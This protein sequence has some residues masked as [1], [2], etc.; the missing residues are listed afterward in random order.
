ME[1]Y[2]FS[3]LHIDSSFDIDVSTVNRF[4][5][6][7]LSTAGVSYPRL[8]NTGAIFEINKIL[9]DQKS[10]L[11]VL[12]KAD[13]SYKYSSEITKTIAQL[14]S[15]Q[16]E[17]ES[18]IN[19]RH[20]NT[21]MQNKINDLGLILR[22]YEISKVGYLDANDVITSAV[23][24]ISDTQYA[25]DYFMFV[26][27][28]DFT[29]QA[30]SLINRLISI[31]AGV[32]VTLYEN[33]DGHNAHIYPNQVRDRLTGICLKKGYAIDNVQSQWSQ[34]DLHAFLQDYLFS[35]NALGYCLDDHSISLYSTD[36]FDDEIEF[37]ARHIRYAVLNGARY[38]DFGICVYGLEQ[39]ENVIRRV[40][41]KYEINHYI[42]TKH[43]IRHT[44]L[45]RFV[46]AFLD[47]QIA[48]SDDNIIALVNSVY[49]P[50]D[51]LQK[52]TIIKD[53]EYSG[54]NKCSLA[55]YLDY[56]DRLK[57]YAID[58]SAS[59][60]Q[61]RDTICRMIADFSV[62]DINTA[63][64]GALDDLYDQKVIENSLDSMLALMDEIVLHY[65]ECDLGE[66]A[67]IFTNALA[68][69][70]ISPLP[71]SMDTV[72]VVEASEN[73]TKFHKL[74]IMNCTNATCP[75]V[76]QDCGVILDKDISALDRCAEISPSIMHINKLNKFH[77]LNS[78]QMFDTTLCITMS[79]SS[80]VEK[81]EL[82]TEL[83]K[84]IS[85]HTADGGEIGL[86]RLSP[87]LMDTNIYE[88]LSRVDLA[89]NIYAKNYDSTTF[90]DAVHILPMRDIDDITPD[91]VSIMFSKGHISSSQIENYFK[92]PFVHFVKNGLKIKENDQKNIK[93]SEIGTIIHSMVE[94]YYTRQIAPDDIETFVDTFV[95]S[96]YHKPNTRANRQICISVKKECVRLL[97]GLA[98]ND[99]MSRFVPTYFELNF[100][101]NKSDFSA[102]PLGDY[103]LKGKVDRVDICD[104]YFRIVDFKTGDEKPDYKDI[105]FGTKIQ[106]FLYGMAL[107][108]CLGKSCAGVFY[109]PISQKYLKDEKNTYK[110]N[111][112]FITENDMA[113]RL[114]VT[115]E[116]EVK[117]TSDIV[118][119]KIKKDGSLY[120]NNY[121]LTSV[122]L[123][124]IFAYVETLATTAIR[125][126]Q[127]GN[128]YPSPIAVQGD[129]CE[130]CDF[131]PL[132]RKNSFSIQHRK[133]G[134][135]KKEDI[136][137]EGDE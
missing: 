82:V 61:V 124:Q 81:S 126:I 114:D 16:I 71:Q 76:I 36:S 97:R 42:D 43:S 74:F 70:Y 116:P 63:I 135:I 137:G 98:Q 111:G 7:V 66:F 14:K 50:F 115:L 68:E 48:P 40:L 107:Q 25:D 5:Q 91:N 11:K 129:V 120:K 21:Q 33:K 94:Q 28:D 29:F 101:R 1:K 103:D 128:I 65:P 39:Y 8:T 119:V 37:V 130:Y 30:Y 62:S 122:E 52:S 20:K 125:E 77:M 85:I 59:A 10:N 2:L 117:N 90:D 93:K 54:N 72:Q 69:V 32:Y 56:I 13:Y 95:D 100:D 19:F 6:S 89:E 105:Y 127:S 132:C 102:Y 46:S 123:S 41:N 51:Y 53:I 131:L 118:N 134:T 84:R 15:S 112:F 57:S 106:L 73:L 34:S 88:P 26:G 80:E 27:Y 99:R 45:A 44:E 23:M 83:E 12:Q 4:C 113:R 133:S 17:A 87:R 64:S 9:T 121:A 108:K 38:A 31:S 60:T 47:Y 3:E 49:S 35:Q 110:L 24:N 55:E 78:V 79:M 92:C 67:D 58:A 96:H 86:T 18:L 75:K 22:E 104:E 109:L 136:I